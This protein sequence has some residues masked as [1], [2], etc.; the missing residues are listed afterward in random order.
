MCPVKPQSKHHRRVMQFGFDDT[1]D[2][3]SLGQQQRMPLNLCANR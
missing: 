3:P 2:Q 1:I